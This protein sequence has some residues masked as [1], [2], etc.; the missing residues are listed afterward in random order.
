MTAPLIW[1][2]IDYFEVVFRGWPVGTSD[3]TTLSVG[4]LNNTSSLNTTAVVLIYS[5][6]ISP[7]GVWNIIANTSSVGSFTGSLATQNVNI[8]LKI[9]I[10]NI[11]D[12]G[13]FTAVLTRLDTNVSETISGSGVNIS[14]QFFLGGG[15]SCVSGA[16]S[17]RVDFDS[18]ELQ[19]K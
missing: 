19:L 9:R 4:L 16:N 14:T 12:S 5:N 13:S 6:N 3:N 15:V 2:N 18:F 8:W 17:K 11:N 10:T 7:T 1:S